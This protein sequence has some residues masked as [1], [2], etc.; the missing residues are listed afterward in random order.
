MSRTLQRREEGIANRRVHPSSFVPR[1]A[2]PVAEG[3]PDPSKALVGSLCRS[4]P[5]YDRLRTEYKDG[6]VEFS[7]VE[8][9]QRI[10]D[11]GREKSG[12]LC[13]DWLT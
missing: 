3:P 1:N 10:A 5:P 13:L 12:G 2:S 9:W 11:G 7:N 8:L 6:Q 4:S